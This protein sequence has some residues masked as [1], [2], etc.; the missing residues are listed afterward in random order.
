MNR[1]LAKHSPL[2]ILA[3]LCIVMAILLPSFRSAG[4]LTSVIYR[5]SVVGIIAVGQLLVIIVGGIDLSVGSVAA[6]G[7]VVMGL[8][9]ASLNVP[10]PLAIAA[11]SAVGL[12]CGAL[13]GLL[14][15]AFR[16]PP[17]I[18]T[19]GMMMAA[20]GTALLLSH[21]SPIRVLD[22]ARFLGGMRDWRIPVAITIAIAI[23]F[24]VVLTMTRF[25]R[26]LYAT[27]G[28]ITG[29]RLS[30]V[31]VSR[32]QTMAFLLCGLLAGFGGVM[33]A[34]PSGCG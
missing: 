21:A 15:T 32:V 24:A 9:M 6:L 5:T 10:A 23:I 30:G 18:A 19:L 16:L 27:G 25:G 29:A 20:R 8:L 1:F 26:S 34:S 4:N 14:V 7:G 2:V 28:N 13:N 31:S 17:F 11:G 12:V 22:S 33:Q 3:A